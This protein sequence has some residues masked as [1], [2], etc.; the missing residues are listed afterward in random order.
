MSRRALLRLTL[1]VVLAF[2]N[3]PTLIAQPPP[4]LIADNRTPYVVDVLVWNGPNG[5]GFV[6]RLA[7]YTWQAFPNA[8]AGSVWRGVFGQA[9]RQH[10]VN[11]TYD[12]GYQGYQSVWWIQ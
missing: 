5:W 11:Y 10:T 12:Q 4:R 8:A 1:L 9:V 2:L 7:P 6:S 3:A